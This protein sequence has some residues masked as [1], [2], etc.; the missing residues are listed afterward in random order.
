MWLART[1]SKH[2]AAEA[3]LL[4]LNRHLQLRSWVDSE[5]FYI[6]TCLGCSSPANL[7]RVLLDRGATQESSSAAAYRY[8]LSSYAEIVS[9]SFQAA[10]MLA[11]VCFFQR[12]AWPLGVVVVATGAFAVVR[13]CL[14]QRTL[15][16]VEVRRRGEIFSHVQAQVAILPAAQI[17]A[18]LAGSVAIA[19]QLWRNA[20][21]GAS[22]EFSPVSAS[23]LAAGNAG[24]L[25]TTTVLT[26]DPLLLGGFALG[27]GSHFPPR[28]TND[29]VVT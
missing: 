26:Q 13:P 22:G 9:L 17:A 21:R 7:P 20:L 27:C 28:C 15:S 24:R 18:S 19:P 3:R 10:A 11:L 2:L 25:W 4:R 16:P 8:P 12:I 6:S 23:M 1:E 14:Q 5:R 29:G